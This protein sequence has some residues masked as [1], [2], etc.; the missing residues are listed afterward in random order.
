MPATPKEI[1]WRMLEVEKRLNDMRP[2][3]ATVIRMEAALKQ[4]EK[5]VETQ[6]RDIQNLLETANKG[7]GVLG[8]VLVIGSLLGW[9]MSFLFKP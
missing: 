2:L 8:A 1:E 7:W 6:S 4:F 9:G 5:I 3:E